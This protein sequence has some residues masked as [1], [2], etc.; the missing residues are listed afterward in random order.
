MV[1]TDSMA[2]TDT[3][4]NQS[5]I[6]HNTIARVR[7]GSIATGWMDGWACF[8]P[9]FL[10]SFLPSFFPSLLP[11]FDPSFPP[12]YYI[13]TLPVVGRDILKLPGDS[14]SPPLPILLRVILQYFYSPNLSGV[15]QV[16]VQARDGWLGGWID[17]PTHHTTPSAPIILD[18]LHPSQSQ[19]QFF[20]ST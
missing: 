4:S 18:C 2:R 5:S 3:C 19:S 16:R 8:V 20:I 13:L 7:T 6:K 9:S 17:V 15:L 14:D 12:P 11:P 10:P 1:C